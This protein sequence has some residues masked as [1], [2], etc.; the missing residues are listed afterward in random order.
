MNVVEREPAGTVTDPGGTAL[1]ELEVTLTTIPPV[2]AAPFSVSVAVVGEP[3][4][5][6]DGF[7]VKLVGKGGV[8]VN[9]P[10]T[11]VPFA[12]AVIEAFVTAATEV[13]VTE[14]VVDVA[15]PGM[16]VLAGTTAIELAE[17]R[18]TTKPAGGAGPLM[19]TMPDEGRPPNT[20]D[21][22]KVTDTGEGGLIVRVDVSVMADPNALMVAVVVD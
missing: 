22:V 16:L 21:G 12:V 11:E 19:V 17:P 14:K 9:V 8:T 13:V 6:V 20:V 15:P 3:P 1:L 18:F 2:G 4:R 10:E 7:N 5:T